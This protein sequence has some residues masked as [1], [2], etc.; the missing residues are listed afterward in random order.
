MPYGIRKYNKLNKYNRFPIK[1]GCEACGYE[2]KLYRHG[3][4]YRNLITFN[5]AYRVVIIR[6]RC[7]SCHKTYSLIPSFI[8]PYR[9]YTYHVIL[10]CLII[11]FKFNYSFS[12]IIK[13]VNSIN[14]MLSINK[15]HLSFW[16]SRLIT[17]LTAIRLFFAQLKIFCPDTKN[18]FPSNLLTMITDFS[19]LR[20]DFNLRFFLDMPKYFFCK[21]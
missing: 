9:Q 21:P 10:T 1:Y 17:S 8:I 3:F 19:R 6:Y 16:K 12:K 11:M 14:C 4:Y 20:Y 7:K 18:V 2:G 15:T 13:F 5:K